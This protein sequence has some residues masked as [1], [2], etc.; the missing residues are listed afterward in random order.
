ML[1]LKYFEFFNFIEILIVKMHNDFKFEKIKSRLHEKIHNM[2]N[3]F[4][5]FVKNAQQ[6]DKNQRRLSMIKS[7]NL[8]FVIVVVVELNLM[9]KCIIFN[10]AKQ[11][12]C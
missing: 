10:V 1:K 4:A 9:I 8:N 3:N 11:L 6:F 5:K 12:I 2:H 7:S